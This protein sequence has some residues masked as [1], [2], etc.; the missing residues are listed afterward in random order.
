MLGPGDEAEHEILPGVIDILR[1]QQRRRA[2]HAGRAA[3]ATFLEPFPE[4]LDQLLEM[5]LEL[6]PF[7]APRL[8]LFTGLFAA[9]VVTEI[10]SG[11]EK[12][13]GDFRNAALVARGRHR[14][15]HLAEDERQ[16]SMRRTVSPS[17]AGS[18]RQGPGN[19]CRLQL[20]T[21]RK[22]FVRSALKRGNAG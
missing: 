13:E 10:E 1:S 5:P 19:S 12:P 3:A 4:P 17:R 7:V 9:E 20:S 14:H 11:I 2:H 8:A 22:S 6:L 21:V 16:G 15:R 18:S